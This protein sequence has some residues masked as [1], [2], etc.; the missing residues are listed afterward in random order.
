MPTP[1]LFVLESRKVML[2]MRERLA[3]AFLFLPGTGR[4]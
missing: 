4:L 2:F 1:L 3:V